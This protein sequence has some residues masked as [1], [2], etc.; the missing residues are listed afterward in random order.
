M[1]ELEYYN[2]FENNLQRE[3]IK[4][5]N[6]LGV[7]DSV[8]LN[9]E[10]IDAKWA[11][12]A[13]DYMAD[14]I[15]QINEYPEVAIAWAAYMGMA[16]AQW[17]DSDWKKRRNNSYKMF[18]GPKGFDDMDDY[19]VEKVLGFPIT[20]MEARQIAGVAYSCAQK[21]INIIQKEQIEFGTAKAFYI[22]SRTVKVMY[23]I[24]ASMQ[25]RRLG[26]KME[27]MHLN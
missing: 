23:R 2:N 3:M 7:M 16:V 9:S 4:L 11:D 21:A 19:I 22:L 13:D 18:Y 1:E 6:S 10:D 14:A 25:L 5:C 26:Y 17:W 27:K 12:Y 20:S 15:E 24:G 8:L